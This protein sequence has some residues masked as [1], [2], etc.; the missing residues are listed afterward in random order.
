MKK[1]LI[2]SYAWPPMEG[3][4]L[5][6]ARKFVKYLPQYGW[7][8][9][10]LTVKPE[11]SQ[12]VVDIDPLGVKVYRTEYKDIIAMLKSICRVGPAA[13][14]SVSTPSGEVKAEERRPG[15][16]IIREA[17]TIP[18][19][20]IGWYWPAVEEGR[21]I[22]ESEH[23]D[24]ILSTSPPE[25]SH[26]IARKLKRSYSIPWVADLRD[27]WSEDHFRPRPALKRTLLR[28][29]ER[30]VLKDADRVIT[31]S[32]PWAESLKS[33]LLCRDSHVRVIENGFDDE[34]FK[35]IGHSKN[36]KFTIIY[37]GKLH[38]DN[39]PI[40]GFL[41]GV[42]DLI[43]DGLIDRNRLQ[44][45]FY[46]FGYDKPD[47]AKLAGD[48]GLS[49]CVREHGRVPY[50]DSLRLQRSS[51]LL[52]FFQWRGRM[53]EGW[54]SAK[55]YD[56]IGSGRP[57]LAVAE[58]DGIIADLISRTGSG[59]VAWQSGEIKSAIMKYYSEYLEDGTTKYSGKDDEIESLTRR[60][61]AAELAG[62]LDSLGA[63]CLQ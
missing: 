7:E 61:R 53:R 45:D 16:S 36:K 44:V 22:I 6:R 25:T 33:S 29:I 51:D 1:I 4:G 54:Y 35:G 37:T 5:I 38:R 63:E 39:Q 60:N 19:D 12:Q 30:T 48:Y 24:A 11:G 13:K 32:K 20:Q 2:I 17:V 23:I 47:L 26:L 40:E 14:H 49:D 57:I 15:V 50:K 42:K 10:V 58:K 41:Q 9:V 27:L 18:D 56:Y 21:K 34:D 28:Q 46:I 3:V 43:S 59:M 62:V 31:V 8:P 55:I 52:L